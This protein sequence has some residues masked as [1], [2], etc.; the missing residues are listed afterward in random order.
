MPPPLSMSTRAPGRGPV[1]TCLAPSADSA[2]L[3][4]PRTEAPGQS[5]AFPDGPG[6]KGQ[7]WAEALAAAVAAAV[8]PAVSRGVAEGLRAAGSPWLSAAPGGADA[9]AVSWRLSGP[10]LGGGGPSASALPAGAASAA[11]PPP[12]ASTEP[13]L[14]DASGTGAL[15]GGAPVPRL[16]P[17]ATSLPRGLNPGLSQASG[18]IRDWRPRHSADPSVAAQG[19]AAL[20][21]HAASL[22]DLVPARKD[23]A[24]AN[25]LAVRGLGRSSFAVRQSLQALGTSEGGHWPAGELRRSGEAVVPLA[26][27]AGGSGQRPA[28]PL[29]AGSLALRLRE[30]AAASCQSNRRG[31]R[32][33]SGA[34][35]RYA[36]S[37]DGLTGQQRRAALRALVRGQAPDSARVRESTQRQRAGTPGA[38]SPAEQEWAT[39]GEAESA[40][41]RRAAASDEAG[42]TGGGSTAGWDAS[43][44]SGDW[45]WGSVSRMHGGS[46]PAHGPAPD[47]GQPPPERSWP[48]RTGDPPSA[49]PQS[50]AAAPASAAAAE[51]AGRLPAAE[52]GTDGA[53]FAALRAVTTAGASDHTTL[54]DSGGDASDAGSAGGQG[55]AGSSVRRAE[56][57]EDLGAGGEDTGS[58]GSDAAAEDE[59]SHS[60]DAFELGTDAPGDAER[61]RQASGGGGGHARDKVTDGDGAS[62]GSAASS[63][64]RE[65][66]EDDVAQRELGSAQT[67][68]PS[69]GAQEVQPRQS[70]AGAG[71]DDAASF[72]VSDRGSDGLSESDRGEGRGLGDLSPGHSASGASFM[73]DSDDDLEP[74]L[75]A[76][77][78]GHLRVASG[79]PARPL[80]HSSLGGATTPSSSRQQPANPSSVSSVRSGHRLASPAD[81]SL[82]LSESDASFSLADHATGS[83]AGFRPSAPLTGTG[84]AASPKTFNFAE[85]A[86][87]MRSAAGQEQA[88]TGPGKA[89]RRAASF[90][91]GGQ[92]GRERPAGKPGAAAADPLRARATHALT[93]GA[94]ADNQNVRG[95]ATQDRAGAGER[96][97]PTGSGGSQLR[98]RVGSDSLLLPSE[99]PSPALSEAAPEL[100]A[101]PGR[102]SRP[103]PKDALGSDEESGSMLDG[104]FDHES[105]FERADTATRQ[106]PVTGT[107]PAEMSASGA[108]RDTLHPRATYP[109]AGRAAAV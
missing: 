86:A 23:D 71:T 98:G 78:A 101:I 62:R 28:P 67:P 83:A 49:P 39:T 53:M 15:S 19:S 41:R 14:P 66:F 92:S 79:A 58:G 108:G 102:D 50:T 3:T 59:E 10:R 11:P 89:L 44:A 69:E 97:D 63:Y 104:T 17:T 81:P 107:L 46:A 95:G 91:G 8:G 96:P 43:D 82:L 73:I 5:P 70:P 30:P 109:Q 27:A 84:E 100:G 85:A 20:V 72:S 52:G 61:P 18:P 54:D 12:A 80:H 33:G 25:P 37:L 36:G 2:P 9:P 106:S 42:S 77:E 21:A 7:P 35:S 4:R 31:G 6:P 29:P 57:S 90:G 103:A 45:T 34:A 55:Q 56:G 105:G 40:C 32:R 48:S 26:H 94:S 13:R 24:D 38:G 68:S 16:A 76:R 65:S 47:R 64:G 93:R 87:A 74:T 51:R 22:S 88:A 60:H 75:Q 99:G 1:A